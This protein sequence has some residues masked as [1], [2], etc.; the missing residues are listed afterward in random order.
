MFTVTFLCVP[1][2]IDICLYMSIVTLLCMTRSLQSVHSSFSSSF[3]SF[4]TF[5]WRWQLH[6]FLTLDIHRQD[7]R[8]CFVS[9]FPLYH[10]FSLS[11]LCALLSWHVSLPFMDCL[12]H[13]HGLSPSLSWLVSHPLMACLA[14][15]LSFF[16]SLS[17]SFC[18]TLFLSDSL[19]LSLTLSLSVSPSFSLSFSHG[20]S[21]SLSWR[22]FLPSHGLSLSLT[23]THTLSWL[24]VFLF[25]WL[26]SVALLVFFLLFRPPSCLSFL[27]LAC[28]TLCLSCLW[29][30]YTYYLVTL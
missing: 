4:F 5:D 15:S 22:V 7:P 6:F 29:H 16:L 30:S 26:V 21:P 18:L 19:W 2:S 12:S 14:L 17:L 1:Y 20:L 8:S 25:I 10:C 9:L 24:L 3:E 13:S 27:Y 11:W 28:L 23:H